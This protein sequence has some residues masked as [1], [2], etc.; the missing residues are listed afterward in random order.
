MHNTKYYS[1]ADVSE[2]L[3]ISKANLRYLET[4]I[5]KLKIRKIRGR[6][7]Y[8]ESNIVLLQSKL[9]EKGILGH[10]IELFAKEPTKKAPKK[11]INN[12]HSSNIL[13]QIMN[14][15]QKFLILKQKLV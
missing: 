1:I 14:L 4:T 5:S 2:I 6:R 7:Y 12:H 8:S 11:S 15:E 9:Q 3:S 10:Q 13:T